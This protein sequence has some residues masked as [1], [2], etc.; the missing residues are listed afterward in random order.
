[1]RHLS[2]VASVG[3]TSGALEWLLSGEAAVGGNF[4][5]PVTAD[6]FYNAH[7]ARAVAVAA[8]PPAD[9]QRG[10]ETGDSA[11]RRVAR[12][13]LLDNG[14][15]RPAAEG[16]AYSRGIECVFGRRVESMSWWRS[17]AALDR[18]CRT[19]LASVARTCCRVAP[20][21][22]RGYTRA[23]ESRARFSSVASAVPTGTSS[24]S[25]R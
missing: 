22:L 25:T 11:P 13:S 7:G 5:W 8:A 17:F 20:F 1:M 21:V 14:N 23:H 2:A 12:V 15:S 10:G 18:Q 4:S 3:V 16:G 24:T 6:R 19:P 9:G